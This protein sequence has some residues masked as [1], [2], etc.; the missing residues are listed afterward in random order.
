MASLCLY[1][2]LLYFLVLTA[3]TSEHDSDDNL[4]ML[5]EHVFSSFQVSVDIDQH[6][7]SQELLT[8]LNLNPEAFSSSSS[9]VRAE[10]PQLPFA[11]LWKYH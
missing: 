5:S 3:I 8:E 1:K 11:V 9:N 4:Y 6:R 7:L 10:V 2:H